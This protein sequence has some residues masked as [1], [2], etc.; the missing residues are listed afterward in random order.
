MEDPDMPVV[1]SL[2]A[3]LAAGAL[4]LAGAGVAA[5]AEQ[6][7]LPPLTISNTDPSFG[8]MAT[9]SGSG[10]VPSPGHPAEVEIV[11][12]NPNTVIF[13]ATA[14]PDA[15]GSWAVPVEVTVD[16]APPD[17]P[18]ASQTFRATCDQYTGSRE[19][20]AL[21]VPVEN[22]QGACLD[23]TCTGD[24]PPKL[25]GCDIVYGVWYD[26]LGEYTVDVD[27]GA[28]VH[29]LY[30]AVSGTAST[31]FKNAFFSDRIRGGET[32]VVLTIT[33]DNDPTALLD[34]AVVTVPASSAAACRRAGTM[35]ASV[36]A[37]TVI[38]PG[39]QIPLTAAGFYP[40]EDVL[41][42]LHST[43]VTL[44][45][46]VADADGTATGSATIPTHTEPGAH[47]ITLTGQQSKA[48]ATVD[49]TVSGTAPTTTATPAPAPSPALA[50]TGTDATGLGLWSVG[51]LTAGGSVLALARRRRRTA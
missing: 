26:G 45:T 36:P 16:A 31:T 7:P 11:Y 34:R 49:I 40:G 46:L 15:T 1:R 14:V 3:V 37:G 42:E 23:P 12:D 17:V 27:R 38:T 19:Y 4:V 18:K 5:A 21:T 43:P 33:G 20:P 51:L 25:V 48:V 50:S 13:P 32:Q 9:L 8:E 47:R 35:S 41:V 28:A 24:Y 44:T 30:G 29:L 39:A 22:Q 2:A 10:C 6:Q